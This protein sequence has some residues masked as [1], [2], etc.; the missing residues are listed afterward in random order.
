M[1]CS[2]GLQP[3]IFRIVGSNFGLRVVG[4]EVCKVTGRAR[5]SDEDAIKAWNAGIR[6]D[7]YGDRIHSHPVRPG[8]TLHL[9]DPV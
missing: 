7:R 8:G 3:Q 6:I 1:P 4:C 9:G 2:C 5:M